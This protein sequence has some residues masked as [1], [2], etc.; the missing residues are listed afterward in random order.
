[1]ANNQCGCILSHDK[2]GREFW[3]KRC[4]D[5]SKLDAE[6]HEASRSTGWQ[7]DQRAEVRA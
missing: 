5:G 4:E 3:K 7:A 1:M 2:Q 6:R